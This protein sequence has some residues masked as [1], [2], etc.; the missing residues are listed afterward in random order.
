M[1][2][3]LQL[4]CKDLFQNPDRIL[5]KVTE[6]REDEI[7][8][9]VTPKVCVHLLVCVTYKHRDSSDYSWMD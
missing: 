2:L 5:T 3:R 8:T 9:P 1:Y 4:T 6:L 7:T